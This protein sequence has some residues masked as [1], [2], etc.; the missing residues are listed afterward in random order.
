MT[1][2]ARIPMMGQG[3][4]LAGAVAGGLNAY[5]G[6]QRNRLLQQQA[7]QEAEL[8]PLKNRLLTAQTG[9]AEQG[10]AK[11]QAEFQLGDMAQ[12]ALIIGPAL[13]QD[14]QRAIELLN[15][16]IQKITARGD[17][18]NHTV[19]LR[20]GLLS[21]NIT[22]DQAISEFGN[23][24][25]AAERMG[26]F[27]QSG[28]SEYQRQNL[29][30]Q[31][32]RLDL[33]RQLTPAQQANISIQQQRLQQQQPDFQ[34]SVAG[35]KEGAKLNVQGRMLPTIEAAK[36]AATEGAKAVVEREG[37]ARSNATAL[38]VYETGMASLMSALGDTSTGPVAG[39]LPAITASQ[40]IAEGA[41]AAMAPVLKQ[42]FRS[43]GEGIFTDKDQEML[44]K[45]L[46]TRKDHPEAAKAKIQGIDAIVR[47]KLNQ[48]AQ[49][50]PAQQQGGS[51]PAADD[52][53]DL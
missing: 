53:S 47:A 50:P 23:V 18:P 34:G 8:Q 32:D 27:G 3:I 44:I 30:L 4:D 52:W 35:A 37:A 43:S 38:N 21:G 11:A 41:Q 25:N 7:D 14:P 1:I 20:D 29:A 22:P 16:R 42:M 19:A 12:D 36:T 13:K 46:P 51:A 39:R 5:Q 45:M 48:S 17:N 24:V 10:L 2:D 33:Q 6:A 49:Q 9:V 15:K 31:K 28:I 40:Q 26:I